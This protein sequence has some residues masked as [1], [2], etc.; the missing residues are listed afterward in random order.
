[1]KD[2]DKIFEYSRQEYLRYKLLVNEMVD[3]IKKEDLDLINE[4]NKKKL[5]AKTYMLEANEEKERKKKAARYGGGIFTKRKRK[6]RR[7]KK[8]KEKKSAIQRENY[9]IYDKLSGEA[10]RQQAE[11]EY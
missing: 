7:E 4:N 3:K 6:T 10:D 5:L 8:Q 1:M 9:K 2:K 11:K